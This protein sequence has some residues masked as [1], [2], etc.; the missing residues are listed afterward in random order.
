VRCGNFGQLHLAALSVFFD[1]PDDAVEFSTWLKRARELRD[2][3][4]GVNYLLRNL[5]RGW[6]E[7]GFEGVRETGSKYMH[8][9]ITAIDSASFGM[10][11]VY[12]S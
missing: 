11:N 9:R 10:W 8:Q 5:L 6:S 3:C 12:K 4:M 2:E 7:G 1:K